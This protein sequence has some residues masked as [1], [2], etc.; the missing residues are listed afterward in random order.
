MTENL[1]YKLK[2]RNSKECLYCDCWNRKK[3][4]G[5]KCYMKRIIQ[6]TWKVNRKEQFKDI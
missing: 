6:R 3:C 2:A 4:S 5:Y 1:S